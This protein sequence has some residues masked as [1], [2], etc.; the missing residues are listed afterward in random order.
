MYQEGR[1][2]KHVTRACVGCQALK[3]KCD[4]NEQGCEECTKKGVE[5]KRP[6]APDGRSAA[7]REQA[8]DAALRA[9]N[10]ALLLHIDL[11]ENENIILRTERA[12]LQTEHERMV[13]EANSL[14]AV[15]Q[16]LREILD[17]NVLGPPNSPQN[18]YNFLGPEA[19]AVLV[20][21]RDPAHDYAYAAQ[22]HALDPDVERRNPGSQEDRRCAPDGR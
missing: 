2:T 20:V 4:A 22:Y 18:A 15:N 3:R 6:S 16:A 1:K 21:G 11:L 7:G 9:Q 10:D 13:V 12:I 17:N 19:A 8:G 5:C 14:S